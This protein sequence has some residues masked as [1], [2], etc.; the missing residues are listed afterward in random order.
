MIM[1]E[2]DTAGAAP[3]ATPTNRFT[4][5]LNQLLLSE[6]FYR[7]RLAMLFKRLRIACEWFCR[8]E[9][10][11]SNPAAQQEQ[12]LAILEE[13]AQLEET[14]VGRTRG[15][16]TGIQREL[17]RNGS[18]QVK[19]IPA[20]GYGEQVSINYREGDETV[21]IELPGIMPFKLS[22]GTHYQYDKVAHFMSEFLYDMRR[23]KGVHITIPYALVIIIHHY[24]GGLPMNLRDYD[25]LE[26][27]CVLNALQTTGLFADSPAHM[28]LM[29]FAAKDARDFTEVLISPVSKLVKTIAGLDIRMYGKDGVVRT[30]SEPWKDGNNGEEPL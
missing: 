27:S 22:H 26:K 16:L 28:V 21:R 20:E 11:G 14:F 7:K 10:L 12:A 9:G 6:V 3:E 17:N 23:N 18:P 15:I 5:S 8:I 19:T 2:H 30:D 1:S 24:T 4:E 29:E 13:L 25:T